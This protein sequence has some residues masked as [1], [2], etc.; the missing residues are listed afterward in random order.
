MRISHRRVQPVHYR[1]H[2]PLVI[3]R[4]VVWVATS[5]YCNRTRVRGKFQHINPHLHRMPVSLAEFTPRER[6]HA[7]H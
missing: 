6:T 1:Q 7:A 5:D 4:I 3:R 2:P